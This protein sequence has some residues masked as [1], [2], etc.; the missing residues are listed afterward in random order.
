[1]SGAQHVEVWAK[2][3]M[4]PSSMSLPGSW[5]VGTPWT[6]ANLRQSYFGSAGQG[7]LDARPEGNAILVA[8]ILE[9]LNKPALYTTGG[10]T[11]VAVALRT[12]TCP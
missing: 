11:Q 6:V 7:N 4:D 1:M 5:D 12:V 9:D 3:C 2:T 10:T 8:A